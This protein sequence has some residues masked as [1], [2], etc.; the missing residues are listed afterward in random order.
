MKA[1]RNAVE[2]RMQ[3]ELVV[4][5]SPPLRARLRTENSRVDVLCVNPL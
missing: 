5:R 4:A 3:N 2:S 1:N